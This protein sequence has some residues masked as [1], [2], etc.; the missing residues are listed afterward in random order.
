ML[1]SPFRQRSVLSATDLLD[2]LPHKPQAHGQQPVKQG[3]NVL[4]AAGTQCLGQGLWPGSTTRGARL[5]AVQHGNIG[6]NLYQRHEKART[7]RKCQAFDPIDALLTARL[8]FAQ[9]A[10]NGRHPSWWG[11]R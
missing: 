8:T 2:L 11:S 9:D 5:E 3:L 1:D 10:S 6:I 4:A 7:M